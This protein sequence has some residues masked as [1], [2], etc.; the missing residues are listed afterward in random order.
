ML[1]GHLTMLPQH[2]NL[3][4]RV[5][6][7]LEERRDTTT[8]L[9]R[10]QRLAIVAA[11]VVLLGVGSSFGWRGV[12]GADSAHAAA[13]AQAS[14]K[15]QGP[16]AQAGKQAKGVATGKLTGQVVNPNGSPAAG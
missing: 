5:A 9:G 4:R 10:W 14:L 8:R 7:L 13:G 16:P 1:K 11:L 15:E 2:Q 6:D 3:E 12:A